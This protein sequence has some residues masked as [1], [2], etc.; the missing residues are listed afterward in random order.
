[1]IHFT[2]NNSSVIFDDLF[3][4]VSISGDKVI[5]NKEL[6]DVAA[7]I[8]FNGSTILFNTNFTYDNIL[9]AYTDGEIV[10]TNEGELFTL[11]ELNVNYNK[12]N[13]S[14]L[15]E[16]KFRIFN[17]NFYV[18][19]FSLF[20]DKGKLSL[21]GEMNENGELNFDLGINDFTGSKLAQI[22]LAQNDKKL[23]S[24]L[25]LESKITGNLNSPVINTKIEIDSVGYD[26]SIFGR[27]SGNIISQD[28]NANL[29]ITFN[30]Y[31]STEDTL[32]YFTGVIPYSES[33]EEVSKYGSAAHFHLF[34]NGFNLAILGNIIPYTKG[35]KGVLT[36]D[37]TAKGNADKLNYSG[38]LSL[39]KGFFLYSDNNIGYEYSANLSFNDDNIQIDKVIL[40]STVNTPYHQSISATGN[41]KLE[42][43]T[44]KE[45]YVTANGNLA[46]LSQAT[47]FVNPNFY[48]D[49]TLSSDGNW[50]YIYKDGKS[51]FTGNIKLTNADLIISP[52]G[53][54][55]VTSLDKI[56]YLIIGDTS[57]VDLEE[58]KFRNLVKSDSTE[59]NVTIDRANFD[60]NFNVIIEK[61]AKLQFL[62]SKV[63]NQKLSVLTK[64]NLKYESIDGVPRAQGSLELQSGSK[65]EF[66]K[67]FDATGNIKFESDITNPYLDVTATYTG[68]YNQGTDDLPDIVDVQVEM[69]LNG[70]LDKLGTN[71][72]Q[73]P[74]NIAIYMGSRNI[75]NKS[76][77]TRYDISDA[78]L[79]IYI[80]RFK[81]DLTANDKNK[82]AGL[83]N[84]ATSFLGSA[85][86]SIINSAVGDVVSD[87]QVDQSGL[88]TKIMISGR[89]QNIR[90]SVGGT[91]R[92]QN[93]SEA[94]LKIE[95]LLLPN[96][97]L[98]LERK[99][100]VVESFGIDEKISELGLK[101][102]IQF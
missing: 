67:S 23:R 10:V 79:F 100:P 36:A 69:K 13:F 75:E 98:R 41:V 4:S 66:V 56:N 91:T 70:T 39:H 53:Q 27:F 9:S 26:E 29:N 68:S 59:N 22:I 17:N 71:L 50:D 81:E 73:N 90:Y 77:E 76:R 16:I 48:G 45:V 94:N 38:K 58:I 47:K 78:I 83:G 1:D 52:S 61:E 12:V 34:T 19:D 24:L 82:L 72:M 31:E 102:R 20:S 6:H 80:G 44:P 8:A 35:L 30:N 7:D 54:T 51:V 96:L 63:W 15:D 40:A 37:V 74:E 65:L 85:L 21:T 62:L 2:R 84:T 14:N 97:L 93:I 33:N 92:I 64:G 87:I 5:I 89:Y 57:S 60:Y 46:V 18:N 42:G 28:G 55:E 86:T 25:N 99:D 49:L 88:D 3:G 32:L 43:I 11:Y 95:Y 101:Y